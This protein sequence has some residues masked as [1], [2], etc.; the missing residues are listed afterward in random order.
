MNHHKLPQQ[1]KSCVVQRAVWPP[2]RHPLT[3]AIIDSD[4]VREITQTSAHMRSIA[5]MELPIF[6]QFFENSNLGFGALDNGI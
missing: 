1:S 3:D 6:H 4:C 2:F 5:K